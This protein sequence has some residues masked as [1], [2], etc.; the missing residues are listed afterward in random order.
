MV[1]RC[2]GVSGVCLHNAVLQK[3]LP[4]GTRNMLRSVMAPRATP[5]AA[6]D[7]ASFS[8]VSRGW[9]R[10]TR[11]RLLPDAAMD[12]LMT[13]VA[14]FPAPPPTDRR[15]AAAAADLMAA[16]PCRLLP[17]RGSSRMHQLHDPRDGLH[18]PHG[19]LARPMYDPLLGATGG[20]AAQESQE[21]RA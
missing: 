16:L 14:W 5:S 10:N 4:P 3:D 11:Y 19:V 17:Y 2:D 8:A 7:Y 1:R 20:A 18:G 9:R 6:W 12:N 13:W 21:S 15:D